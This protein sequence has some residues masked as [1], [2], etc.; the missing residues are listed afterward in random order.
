MSSQAVP[1]DIND[2]SVT[3]AGPGNVRHNSSDSIALLSVPVGCDGRLRTDALP[4]VHQLK[5][6]ARDGTISEVLQ[7]PLIGWRLRTENRFDGCDLTEQR[8]TELVLGSR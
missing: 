4:V 3:L 8:L 7:L 6:Q 2:N 1:D 5:E